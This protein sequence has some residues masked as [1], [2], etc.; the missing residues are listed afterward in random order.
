MVPGWAAVVEVSGCAK[1]LFPAAVSKVPSRD[2]LSFLGLVRHWLGSPRSRKPSCPGKLEAAPGKPGCLGSQPSSRSWSR[3]PGSG[4]RMEK[5]RGALGE[6]LGPVWVLPSASGAAL[7]GG[8]GS[9]G[10]GTD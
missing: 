7:P 3:A 9:R 1:L 4:E 6:K 10:G 2:S 5:F 8:A